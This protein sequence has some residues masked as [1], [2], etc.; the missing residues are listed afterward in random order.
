M[1]VLAEDPLSV[2]PSVIRDIE[3]RDTIVGGDITSEIA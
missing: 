2:D 1:T 3:V